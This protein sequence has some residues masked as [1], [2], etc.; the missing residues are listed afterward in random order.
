MQP[1]AL[2]ALQALV[3]NRLD[4]LALGGGRFCAILGDAPSTYAKSP[5]LWNAAFRALEWDAVYIPLDVPKG[6][7]ADV[8]RFLRENEAYLGGNVTVP[9]KR[10]VIP[11]LD[12]LDPSAARVGAVNTIARSAQG[13]LTGYN[14]DGPGGVKALLPEVPRLSEA[15]VLLLGAGGSAQAMAV[16][17]WERMKKGQLLI[18]NRTPAAAKDLVKRLSSIRQG[19]LAAISEDA[20]PQRIQ[21]FDLIVNTTVKG[22]AGIR[23][24]PDGRWTCLEPYSCLGPANPAELAPNPKNEDAFL[25]AWFK[26]S[27]P[28]IRRNFDIS[29]LT[30]AKLPRAAFCY[31]IVYAPTETTFL[32]QA[33]LSGHGTLN[34]QGMNVHQAV[35]AFMQYV[36]PELVKQ[37]GAD[38][39]QAHARVLKAMSEAWAD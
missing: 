31:D 38:P 7:L 13:K 3:T 39:E 15:S 2:N 22:Q 26:K 17:L 5:K 9:Y 32:R 6:K 16:T 35:E 25:E 29:M 20:I 14:S 19:K 24:L 33:R 23:K 27:A 37:A 10:D 4:G 1:G 21:E 28:D 34:G 8:V 30:I 12:A 18:S 11:L 36:C